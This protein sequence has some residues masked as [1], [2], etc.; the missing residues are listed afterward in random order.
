MGVRWGWGLG[1]AL[2][3]RNSSSMR[4]HHQ[5]Q[6]KAGRSITTTRPLLNNNNSITNTNTNNNTPNNIL[7]MRHPSSSSSS[8]HKSTP[9]SSSSLRISGINCTSIT[10]TSRG[11][12][13]AILVSNRELGKQD[14]KEVRHRDRA[15][16]R[17]WDG[18]H[19]LVLEDPLAE[20]GRMRRSHPLL[21]ACL[22]QCLL[23]GLGWGFR[24]RRNSILNNSTEGG[25]FLTRH[26]KRISHTINSRTS[27]LCLS[28]RA[29]VG[30][31][32]VEEL[33]AFQLVGWRLLLPLILRRRPL[34]SRRLLQ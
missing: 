8:S 34:R 2:T 7:K 21:R 23:L 33:A 1:W 19:L 16:R 22:L 15:Q 17:H 24:R 32:G 31:G 18:I 28:R 9:S 13:A 27:K 26:S 11:W 20:R 30:R 5:E 6:R 25:R 29:W 4:R 14:S 10:S 12:R 3:V